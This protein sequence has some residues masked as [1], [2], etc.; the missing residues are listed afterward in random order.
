MIMRYCIVTDPFLHLLESQS[1]SQRFS[2]ILLKIKTKLFKSFERPVALALGYNAT[3]AITQEIRLTGWSDPKLT[4]DFFQF[5]LQSLPV[6]GSFY[7]SSDITNS[8]PIASVITSLS[9]L[10]TRIRSTPFLIPNGTLYYQSREGI[11]G[12]SIDSFYFSVA[13]GKS[14]SLDPAL[15]T[16]IN[17]TWPSDIFSKHYNL[18]CARSLSHPNRAYCS[19]FNLHR[20]SYISIPRANCLDCPKTRSNAWSC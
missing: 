13:D 16:P 19:C 4:R 5:I 8:T 1:L 7:Q 3:E 9:P 11:C 12:F 15:G 2:I 18:L 6:Q 10:L 14:S 20:A 17:S